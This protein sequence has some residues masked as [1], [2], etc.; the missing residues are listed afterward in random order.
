MADG[1]NFLG[2]YLDLKA[3][4][5]QQEQFRAQQE[6][7]EQERIHRGFTQALEFA[8][9]G[10]SNLALNALSVL[11]DDRD[12]NEMRKLVQG[13]AKSAKQ[14]AA[15]PKPSVQTEFAKGAAAQLGA[16]GDPR[17]QALAALRG[18]PFEG[19]LGTQIAQRAG[20]LA[21]VQQGQ[22]RQ[23]EQK[24]ITGVLAAGAKQERKAQD[25]VFSVRDRTGGPET[26]DTIVGLEAYRA[27]KIANPNLI[28]TGKPTSVGSSEEVFGTPTKTRYA[29]LQDDA[30]H[31]D[32][33]A[34]D[35]DEAIAI[36]ETNPGL[37][38]FVGTVSRRAGGAWQTLQEMAGVPFA[39]GV[40]ELADETVAK[41]ISDRDS[42]AIDSK[43]ANAWI[44]ALTDNNAPA[45]DVL[46]AAITYGY[47]RALRGEGKLT[48]D[49]KERAENAVGIR[50]GLTTSSAQVLQRLKAARKRVQRLQATSQKRLEF[51]KGKQP[52][53]ATRTPEEEGL[54]GIAPPLGTLSPLEEVPEAF[55]ID[56]MGG[57]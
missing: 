23:A 26:A 45:L 49:D 43:G 48:V 57:Q 4:R 51:N 24:A 42:G 2:L 55:D 34:T 40:T 44:S 20:A 38:G 50:T 7:H 5:Q 27:A 3:R 37:A 53:G 13:V 47:A 18:I 41:I 25:I 11:T 14:R 32:Q 54:I 21:G 52:A 16:P 6:A 28:I 10:D 8:N 56:L 33:A 36:I 12:T 31:L 9:T 15:T 29:Q 39:G 22:Q 19:E 17:E 30:M 46:G 1:T 35:F